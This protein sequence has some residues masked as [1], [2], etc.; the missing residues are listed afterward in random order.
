MINDNNESVTSTNKENEIDTMHELADKIWGEQ[1][2]K[3]L[4][5]G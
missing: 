3:R 5:T 4:A 2:Y 1:V